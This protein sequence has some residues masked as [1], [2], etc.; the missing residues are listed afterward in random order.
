[1]RHEI[2]V[3][4]AGEAPA[5]PFG[6]KTPFLCTG[7]DTGLGGFCRLWSRPR[8]GV[9]GVNGARCAGNILRS[10]FRA[11]GRHRN[12]GIDSSRNPAIISQGDALDT[13]IAIRPLALLVTG[14]VNPACHCCVAIALR[15]PG[16]PGCSIANPQ[17]FDGWGGN[18]LG[19]ESA[20]NLFK[21]R[22]LPRAWLGVSVMIRLGIALAPLPRADAGVLL[23]RRRSEAAG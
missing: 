6:G 11:S 4:C 13:A 2:F 16:T 8:C 12:L 5:R 19:R 21:R 23:E 9:G 14:R 15:C 20:L 18:C 17:G 22:L 7:P 10:L 1:M 3:T